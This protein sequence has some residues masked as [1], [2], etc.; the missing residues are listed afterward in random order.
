MQ[1]KTNTKI[2][3]L[4]KHAKTNTLTR[5]ALA[6]LVLQNHKQKKRANTRFARGKQTNTYKQDHIFSQRANIVCIHTACWLWRGR[7]MAAWGRYV[8]EFV[9]YWSTLW[10]RLNAPPLS[11][12]GGFGIA[13]TWS[14]VSSFIIVLSEV[15]R[16]FND[17]YIYIYSLLF[18]TKCV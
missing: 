12:D 8:L 10:L 2:W 11:C 18:Y 1:K 14:S 15:S 5:A 7:C 9:V 16:V 6:S 13:F 17:I 3:A 4:L